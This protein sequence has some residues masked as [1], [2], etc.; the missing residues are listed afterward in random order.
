MFPFFKV[1]H[2]LNISWDSLVDIHAHFLPGIDDGANDMHESMLMIK[3]MKQMGYSKLIATPH[4]F[5][6]YYPNTKAKIIS[7]WKEVQEYLQ[8][9][10][11]VID[12][13]VAAE[14]YLDDHFMELLQ[15]NELLLIAEKHLL[16]ETSVMGCS[17]KL[18]EY[19]W[20]INVKGYYP[21]LAHPERYLFLGDEDYIRLLNQGCKFQINL[22]SLYGYYGPQVKKRAIQLLK[23]NWVHFS[24][25]DA[26]SIHQ[27]NKLEL[28]L[29][30]KMAQKTYPK[31]NNY[32]LFNPSEQQNLLPI[33]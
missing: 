24:G 26:H 17:K 8:K 6:D 20:E 18:Y 2:K 22:L 15:T 4:I 33:S 11:I 19:L 14:Y 5:L 23:N 12:I 27:L 7:V 10:N 32:N 30:S 25:T 28:F 29:Q 16:V 31:I 3:K 1:N 21:I 13:S 9:E